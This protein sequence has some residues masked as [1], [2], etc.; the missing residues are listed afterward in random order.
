MLDVAGTAEDDR[1]V[2]RIGRLAEANGLIRTEAE[3]VKATSPTALTS[4]SA[5]RERHVAFV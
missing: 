2:N 1:E 5:N 3:P 4:L